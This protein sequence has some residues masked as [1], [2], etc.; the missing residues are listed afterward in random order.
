MR[1]PDNIKELVDRLAAILPQSAQLGQE[2]RTKMEQTLQKGFKE[3]H[4][5]TR[6]EF[7]ASE[8]AVARMEQRIAELEQRLAELEKGH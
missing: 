1:S 7:A 8:A 2:L 3:M 4:L 5:L 6:E